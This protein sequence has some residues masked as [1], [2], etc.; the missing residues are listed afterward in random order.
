MNLW[1]DLKRYGA[2][3]V[4]NVELSRIRGIDRTRVDG[5]VRRHS[6]LVVT[7]LSVLLECETVFEI[8]PDTGDTAWLLAHNLPSARIF[9]LE[10][11]SEATDQAKPGRSD[12]LYHLSRGDRGVRPDA[13]ASRIT[14]LSGDSAS[15]DFLAYSGTFDLVYIEGSHR[16]PS[17]RSDTEAA[18]GLLAELGTIVWDGY[19]GDPGVYAY[20]NDLAPSLDRP[21]FHL[22][23]TRLAMYSR[24]DT[25]LPESM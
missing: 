2:R 18:F 8:G 3:R 21:I 9:M 4:R 24:W 16:Y 15:F 7:A 25:V 20:L 5:P 19:S 10:E 13:E 14:R 17:V 6:P 22:L 1:I 12:Q 23:G 11:G